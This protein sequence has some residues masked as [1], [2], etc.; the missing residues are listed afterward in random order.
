M[1][2]TRAVAIVVVA[3]ALA[4]GTGGW[5]LQRTQQQADVYRKA[6]L[7]EDV[8]AHVA[9]YYVDSLSPEQLY[10]LAIDG[11]L[12]KLNDPYT[13]FLTAEA[14]GDLRLS[15]T[16]NYG[17]V[18]LQIISSGG[19]ITVISPI[20]DTP[21]ERAGIISGDQIVE[22]EGASTEGWSSQRAANVLRGEPGTDVGVTIIRAGLR[23]SL[24]FTITR[25]EVHVNS[26]E[27]PMLLRPE[28]GYVRV[29][30]VAESSTDELAGAIEK[31][32]EAGAQRLV[33]DLRGNP[34]GVLEQGVALAD[35]FLERGEVVVE[36][37]GRAPG[38]TNTYRADRSER[39]PDLP[40]VVLVN[41]GT[42]SAAE[43]LAGA[44]QDHDRAVVLG[45]PTFGK[46]VAYV[47]IPLSRTEAVTVTTSR[48]YTPA[49]R[50]IDRPRLSLADS[51]RG[52]TVVAGGQPSDSGEVFRSDAGRILSAGGGI[53]PDILV[54]ADTL[55]ATERRFGEALGAN[56][57]VYRDALTRYALELK[58]AG[59][60]TNPS[61]EVTETMLDGLRTRLADRE[62][63][64]PDSIWTGGEDL[65]ALQLGN[66]IA[67]YVFGR[68]AELERLARSDR[69][70]RRAVE[71]LLA[72]DSPQDLLE[73]AKRN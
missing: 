55:T 73:L 14:Y 28:V 70:I 72:A 50:S 56:V 54:S 44:L 43:I 32:R 40:M 5:L 20:A 34:G 2:R 71:L 45:T 58:G 59:T 3:I 41:G 12:D 46:G 9:D 27:G 24:H 61:F 67:R 53:H 69:Q 17:G 1:K 63:A 6:R 4:A 35:L 68:A 13:N 21:A 65:I 11:M 22:V 36:T 16:G 31:S 7:F 18:G 30:N 23:D 64:M 19:W 51:G 42:A 66:E 33:L 8:L 37:R 47:L 38:S 29:S 26:V 10:E 62:V 49:G 39:W 25:A 60:V 15:T 48:W 57:P 52:P